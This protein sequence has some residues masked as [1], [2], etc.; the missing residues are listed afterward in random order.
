MNMK[1]LI[2]YRILNKFKVIVWLLDEYKI[3]KQI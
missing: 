2:E 1:L 3:N